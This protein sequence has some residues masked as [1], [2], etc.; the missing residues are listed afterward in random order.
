MLW[1]PKY[2]PMTVLHALLLWSMG[3]QE[4]ENGPVMCNAMYMYHFCY[5][6]EGVP[7]PPLEFWVASA[8]VL[9]WEVVLLGSWKWPHDKLQ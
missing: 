8:S 6:C 1:A 5:D 9:W 3:Y 2:S 7:L 4:A